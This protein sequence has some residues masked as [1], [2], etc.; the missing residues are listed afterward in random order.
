ME[1]QKQQRYQIVYLIQ[2]V[3]GLT[4]VMNYNYDDKL[5]HTVAKILVAKKDHYKPQA[6]LT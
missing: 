4:L 1:R 2:N 6:M 3:G 5:K